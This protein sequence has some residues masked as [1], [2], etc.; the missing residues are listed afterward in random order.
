MVKKWK[1][2]TIN[3]KCQKTRIEISLLSEKKRNYKNNIR[4]KI[5]PD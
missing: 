5:N 4:D 3:T 1:I 2:E